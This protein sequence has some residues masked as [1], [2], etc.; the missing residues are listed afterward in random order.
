MTLCCVVLAWAVACWLGEVS[1][2]P[3]W[4]HCAQRRRCNHQPLLARHSSQPVPLGGTA[5]AIRSSAIGASCKVWLEVAGYVAAGVGFPSRALVC[6][7][8]K[9]SRTAID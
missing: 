8:S 1:Q 7:R 6:T 4:P 3:M 9:T 2:H 5:G